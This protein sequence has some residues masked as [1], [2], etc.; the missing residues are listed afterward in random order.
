MKKLF[1]LLIL[2]ILVLFIPFINAETESLYVDSYT[3]DLANW[4]ERNAPIPYL[5]DESTGYIHEVKSSGATEGYFGFENPSGTGTI[6]SVT[7]YIECYG[8]DTNDKIIIYVD[9]S[10]GSGWLMEGEIIVNQNFYDWESLSLSTRLDSWPDIQNAQIYLYYLGIGGGDD[11]Y[12]RRAYLY[13]N[14]DPSSGTDYTRDL[15]QN[16]NIALTDYKE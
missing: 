10:D 3:G 6:N 5:A 15:P 4:D 12:V 13:V 2:I 11:I 7:L 16:M 8:D 9:C 1:P 14:Y